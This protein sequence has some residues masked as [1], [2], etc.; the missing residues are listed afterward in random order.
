[1]W[2]FSLVDTS[3]TPALGYMERVQTRNAATL[4]PIIQAHV[5]PGTIIHSNQ[6][7]AC[8]HLLHFVDLT[9]GIHTQNIEPFWERVKTDEGC[10]AHQIP[11][12]LDEFMWRVRHGPTKQAAFNSIIRDIAQQ[13]PV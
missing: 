1:M 6:W 2:V 8:N 7:A 12:Y 4:L 3:H 5:A 13:Y 11:S 10:H 9:T